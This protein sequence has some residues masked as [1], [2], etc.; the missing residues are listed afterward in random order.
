MEDDVRT[1]VLS[2]MM[3]MLVVAG[4][5]KKEDKAAQSHSAPAPEATVT[6]ETVHQAV[7]NTVDAVKETAADAVEA[8]KQMVEDS[9]VTEL[10]ETAKETAAAAG[11]EAAAQVSDVAT[12]V[13]DKVV[14]L[15]NSAQTTGSGLLSAVTDKV[16]TVES[17]AESAGSAAVAEATETAAAATTAITPPETI[18]IENSYANVTLPH[19]FH[20]ESFGCPTCHGANTPGPF[21]LGKA[22]AHVLCKD[23]HKE[24]GGPTKCGGCH[25]K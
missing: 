4:C 11:E 15:S 3:A 13:E 1:L 12:A 5:G 23:C 25:V 24:Q 20:G 21:E 14:D 8:G 7:E 9:G 22:T 10:A 19:A 18:V 6:T 16:A 2:L 17:D